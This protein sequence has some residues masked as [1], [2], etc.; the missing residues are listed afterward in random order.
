MVVSVETSA[1]GI[2]GKFARSKHR[3][4]RI[5]Q[6]SIELRVCVCVE[7]LGV[8]VC[9]T[10]TSTG[11]YFCISTCDVFVFLAATSPACSICHCSRKG[12]HSSLSP[13]LCRALTDRIYPPARTFVS[14]YLVAPT[15]SGDRRL[16]GF[17]V[18]AAFQRGHTS[19]ISAGEKRRL[20]D[21]S[22]TFQPPSPPVLPPVPCPLPTAH[23]PPLENINFRPSL[24]LPNGPKGNTKGDESKW[25]WL[26][27]VAC[28][29]VILWFRELHSEPSRKRNLLLIPADM[30]KSSSLTSFSTWQ[31]K[32]EYVDTDMF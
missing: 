22:D 14:V 30:G 23:C 17:W 24:W 4:R 16:A 13:S 15:L 10:N 12:N 28:V 27:C 18:C 3:D 5:S 11:R 19:G 31:P 32:L 25:K 8:S 9:A 20:R 2:N 7:C 26:L 6:L 1:F 21:T 29:G